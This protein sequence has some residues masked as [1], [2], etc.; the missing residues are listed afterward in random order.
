MSNKEYDYIQ[1]E[2]AEKGY[3]AVGVISES[4][5]FYYTVGCTNATGHEFYVCGIP[6]EKAE[7]VLETLVGFF[8]STDNTDWPDLFVV[9]GLLA[10]GY[11]LGFAAL[12]VDDQPRSQMVHASTHN[13][14][15]YKA[16]QVVFP[17]EL[18]CLPWETGYDN[19]PLK[20]QNL[21]GVEV[22]EIAKSEGIPVPL[23]EVE[24]LDSVKTLH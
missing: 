15:D 20:S 4:Q 1:A 22:V 19:S 2:I 23:I 3:A 6:P 10:H 16:Y 18:N 17:N 5:A 9:S 11:R 8:S 12:S 13:D 21:N 14:S 24:G 7:A